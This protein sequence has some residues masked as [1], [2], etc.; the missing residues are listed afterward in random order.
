MRRTLLRPLAAICAAASVFAVAC[1]MP[2]PASDGPAAL[3]PPDGSTKS[4]PKTAEVLAA[5]KAAQGLTTIP[6]SVLKSLDVDDGAGPRGKSECHSVADS[7]QLHEYAHFGECLY[8]DLQGKELMVVFGDSRANMWASALEGVAAQNNWKLRVFSDPACPIP[9]LP[10][11]DYRT[12]STNV[13]CDEFRRRAATAINAMRPGLVVVTSVRSYTLAEGGYPTPEQWTTGWVSTLNTLTQPGTKVAMIGD[14]P[15]WENSGSRCL[16][17]HVDSVQNCSVPV[18]EV[19]PEATA[20]GM[21]AAQLAAE[22]AAATEVDA[23]YIPT[24]PWICADRCEPVIAD[25]RVFNDKRHLTY[26]YAV[27]LTGALG[28]S[29]QRVLTKS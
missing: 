4:Y 15:Q 18:G 21:A 27:F 25:R 14:L 7:P 5:V 6:D 17:A 24:T 12:N 29:L 10:F 9:D 26:Q 11:I 1:S 3:G 19:S 20:E 16:A 13:I 28:D 22:E 2:R 8:G 23:L